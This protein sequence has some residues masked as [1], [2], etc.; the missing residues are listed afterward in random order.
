V[1]LLLFQVEGQDAKHIDEFSFAAH[2]LVLLIFCYH[3]EWSLLP[4][5]VEDDTYFVTCILYFY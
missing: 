2:L 1:L 3:I 5:V 4:Q